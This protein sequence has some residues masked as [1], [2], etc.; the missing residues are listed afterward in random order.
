MT[1]LLFDQFPS[2]HPFE[3]GFCG[4]KELYLAKLLWCYLALLPKTEAWRH[5]MH[6]DGTLFLR[7][8]HYTETSLLY[9]L[10]VD[11][12]LLFRMGDFVCVS[13]HLSYA[14]GSAP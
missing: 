6:G 4:V 12:R 5:F 9:K 10:A 11:C 13:L 2:G 3:S 7:R 8:T 14:R 1:G